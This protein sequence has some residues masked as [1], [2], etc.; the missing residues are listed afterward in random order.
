MFKEDEN[1][2]H[3]PL[4]FVSKSL[5]EVETQYTRLELAALA[6]HLAAKKLF[7][8]F[9]AHPI[10]VLTNL[11]L[12]STIHKPDLL[13]RMAR[14]AIE[15]SEFSIQYKPSLAI[16]GQILSDFLA[17]I[18]QQDMD[19]GNADWWILNVDDASRQTGADVG[20]QLKAPTEERIKQAKRLDFLVSNNEVEYKVILA[21]ID[22]VVSISSEKII[23]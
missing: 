23:I 12:R 4:F 20:L 14:W 9:Q 8:Y 18:P 2:K 5:S 11:P 19:P 15:L 13:G 6:L 22:L 21:Y 10:V 16:K 1:R 7:P 17:K 3:R